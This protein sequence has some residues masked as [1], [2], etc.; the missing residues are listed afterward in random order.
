VSRLVATLVY[1][2]LRGAGHELLSRSDLDLR[3]ALT[4]HEALAVSRT[5]KLD[6]VLA[7]DHFA[8][9]YLA[10]RKDLP[11][12]PPCIVM[13]G[14]D[15][16]GEPFREA[17]A[18]ALVSATDPKRIV[19]AISEL[20][21]LA[22]R[23]HPRVPLNTVVDVQKGTDNHL[24][25]TFDLSVS[26]VC[27]RDFPN[28]TYGE[29][30]KVTFDLFDPPLMAEAMVVRTF[31]LPDAECTGLCFTNL[32][33]EDR[34]RISKL[35]DKE[36]VSLPM[37]TSEISDALGE[38]TMDLLTAMQRKEDLG[39]SEYMN[40]L[41]GIVEGFT[42]EAPSW[43]FEVAAKLTETERDTLRTTGPEWAKQ[44]ALVRVDLKRQI[45]D[46]SSKGDFGAAMEFC[47]AMATWTKDASNE[48]AVDATMIRSAILRAVYHLH[49]HVKEREA[50]AARKTKRKK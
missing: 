33:D 41:S 48:Q 7:S 11:T 46:R 23:N 14:D 25:Y 8:L 12:Q 17:G 49:Q 4:L 35:V 1:G 37:F 26:G 39:L 29:T 38:Q 5:V 42:D 2:D 43:I 9:A 27:I 47:S 36:L 3:W 22:F 44:A 31:N 32:T 15:V 10:A 20:T 24:L 45:I 40:M 50:V 28:P 19:E 21:G 13:V 16:D 30:A 18:T 34:K 6:L